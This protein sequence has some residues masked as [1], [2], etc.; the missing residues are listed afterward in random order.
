MSDAACIAATD[1]YFQAWNVRSADALIA[2]F[3]PDGTYSDPA[4]S[5]E[6]VGA[7]IGDY[8]TQLW[9]AFPDLRFEIEHRHAIAADE[10]A[11]EWLMR[12]TNTASFR[13]LP[14]TGRTIAVP[15]IDYMRVRGDRI[16]RVRGY[17]D[18]VLLLE[19]AGFQVVVQPF[20]VGPVEF[21]TATH[22]GV[23]S[24]QTPGAISLTYID[25]RSPDEVP[26][27]RAET[28]S[29]VRELAGAPGFLGFVGAAVGRR[30]FTV[31]AWETPEHAR[32]MMREGAHRE[33]ARSFL[34]GAFGAALQTSVWLP[35]HINQTWLGCAACG[36]MNG[37]RSSDGICACG[38]AMPDL[39]P[40]W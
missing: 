22:V 17:F 4:T 21:G 33:S 37:T 24:S 19:Q 36:R 3:T 32:S 28:R 1:R 9:A 34:G 23:S 11:I 8:A 26:R 15:G 7:A 30:L 16:A 18:R 29:V 39:P 6:L 20:R 12:G 5:G 25:V 14:P 35:G 27:V 31:T 10:V 38:A 2:A 40:F 13:G